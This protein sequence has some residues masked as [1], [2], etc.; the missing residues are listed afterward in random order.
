[1]EVYWLWSP[2]LRG[3]LTPGRE[4]RDYSPI[5]SNIY[6]F[7]ESFLFKE[8]LRPSVVLTVVDKG[9]ILLFFIDN[10]GNLTGVFSIISIPCSAADVGYSTT[11]WVD[12]IS[13][14]PAPIASYGLKMGAWCSI[15]D[16]CFLTSI[17]ST[18]YSISLIVAFYDAITESM[19]TLVS[20]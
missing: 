1:M 8:L 17:S 18:C 6:W 11:P 19:L 13:P 16:L 7:W 2:R 15:L 10:F 20:F 9:D 3:D 14:P 12:M 5:L 4:S